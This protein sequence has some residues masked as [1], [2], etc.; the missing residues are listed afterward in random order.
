MDLFL[1][2][3]FA[4]IIVRLLLLLITVFKRKTRKIKDS[5]SLDEDD[6]INFFL[7]D[8]GISFENRAGKKSAGFRWSQVQSIETY[9]IDLLTYDEAAL[10]FKTDIGEFEILEGHSAFSDLAAGLHEIF[11]VDQEWYF[12]VTETAFK[13]NRRVLYIR[14]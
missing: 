2:I 14:D 7:E 4:A 3:V 10:K 12:E 8:D 9:K 1:A 13:E 6:I 5:M 11:E